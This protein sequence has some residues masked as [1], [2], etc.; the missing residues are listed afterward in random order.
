MNIASLPFLCAMASALALTG[1]AAE[2]QASASV[3]VRLGVAL[4][5]SISEL[6][7]VNFWNSLLRSKF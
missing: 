1:A 7:G 6:R 5:G 2:T 4:A 3:P